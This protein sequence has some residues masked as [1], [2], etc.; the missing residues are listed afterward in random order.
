MRFLRL[1]YTVLSS[2]P[3]M[4]T[5]VQDREVTSV[6]R[7]RNY[8]PLLYSVA[9]LLAA[10]TIVY[11]AAWMYYI[12]QMPRVEVGIDES[13]S[14]AGVEIWNVRKDSPAETAGLK[15]ND[16]IVAINGRSATSAPRWSGLLFRTWLSAR[17]GD[18]VTLTVQ[19]PGQSQPLVITPVF[20]ALQGAGDTKTL[21]RT[22]AGQILESYPRP[23]PLRRLGG[24]VFA[25]GRPLCMAAGAGIR[26]L[27][28]RC[29]HAKRICRCATQS[30]VFPARLPHSHG[31]SSY[32]TVLLFFRGIPRALPD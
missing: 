4:S 24:T 28:H 8:A 13:Y 23:V 2:P 14:S 32:W 31:Q 15:T 3:S 22:I 25:G 30:S 21:A 5:A 12:R 26:S 20:R 17:P 6:A 16:R 7:G 19:R 1:N 10:M 11:S 9:A 27:R 18:T 29:G